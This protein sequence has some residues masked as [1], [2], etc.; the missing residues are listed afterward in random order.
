MMEQVARSQ[1]RERG[2]FKR[3]TLAEFRILGYY[4]S[5]SPESLVASCVA[6]SSVAG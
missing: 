5:S 4:L 1:G 2:K 6:S 3:K